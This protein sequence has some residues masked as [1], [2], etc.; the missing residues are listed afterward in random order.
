MKNE[1]L[2]AGLTLYAALELSRLA[3]TTKARKEI[4]NRDNWECQGLYGTSCYW[5]DKT[6]ESASHKNG[7]YVQAAHWPETHQS[8][9]DKNKDRGRILCSCCHASEEMLRGNQWGAKMILRS[10]IMTFG[11]AERTDEQLYM[12]VDDL[13]EFIN[14][15]SDAYELYYQELN[16]E[17][18]SR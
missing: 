18:Y 17:I 6:G 9:P 5:E 2:V 8:K 1:T 13:R 4:G 7:Y 11:H 14:D 3:F 10:G 12:G 16:I 15:R